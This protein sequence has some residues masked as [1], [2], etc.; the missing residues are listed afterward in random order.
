MTGTQCNLI[1]S[2]RKPSDARLSGIQRQ[3]QN[4]RLDS[5]F[6]PSARPGMTEMDMA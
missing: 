2:F 5:G 1:L 3:A 4:V 6:A